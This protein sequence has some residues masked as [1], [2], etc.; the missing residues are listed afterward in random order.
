MP[1][2]E[3]ATG[4]SSPHTHFRFTSHP[5]LFPVHPVCLV[6]FPVFFV[7]AELE[8]LVIGL[9]VCFLSSCVYQWFTPYRDPTDNVLQLLCQIA[10]F[11]ALLSKVI[12]DHP[13]VSDSQSGICLLYTSPSPR[14]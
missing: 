11:F 3:S 1:S 14:D 12:L 13:E 4:H 7:D 5:I 9:V 6:G 2:Q 8:Q 10:I